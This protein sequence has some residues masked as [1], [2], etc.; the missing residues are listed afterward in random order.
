MGVETGF[1]KSVQP[2]VPR[3]GV[4][5][6]GWVKAPL[7][8]FLEEVKRPLRMKDETEYDL[9]TVKRSRGGVIRREHL[10]G[11]EIAV[12]NQFYIETGDF[13]I[14]KR[15]I[16]HG[17]CGI[18]PKEMSGSIVSNEYSVLI[19]KKPFDIQF[20]GYLSE[21]IY[22]QQT[23][24]H[25]SIG[26]HVEK[27]IFKLDRW[28]K[29]PFNLPPFKEQTKIAQIIMTWDKAI[30][31]TERL[32][33]CSQLKKR[34]L[35]QQVLKGKKRFPNFSDKWKTVPLNKVCNIT[36]GKQLN[37][38]TLFDSGS[39]SVIN[40]GITPSGYCETF[41]TDANTITISEGG[42]SCGY[43]SFLKEPFWC[44]G[45][46]YALK[47]VKLNN[48]YLYQFL[49]F[50]EPTIMRLRVGSGLPNIQKKAIESVKILMPT[51]A[52]QELIAKVL[53]SADEEIES[54]QK[55]LYC[56]KLEKKALMQQLLTGKKRVKV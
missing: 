48:N 21:S 51:I 43:V 39:F 56:L 44:G 15:Q 29:W 47:E 24:F 9:V 55:K 18:V 42:N 3:L 6:D 31:T 33:I 17:A 7:G 49:K 26:V 46:C 50:I 19:V 22:F 27:M 16:V 53:T 23:C 28:L 32:L 5:P 37:K 30:E 20:L 25:S 10:L 13:L 35:M 2:G 1:P 54:L 4:L 11:K 36:K 14:S 41:N 40:G 45:H 52:E 12:K 38:N 34:A 8:E